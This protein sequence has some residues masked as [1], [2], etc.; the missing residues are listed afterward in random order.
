MA[1]GSAQVTYEV[2]PYVYAIPAYPVNIT[3]L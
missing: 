1:M 3:A 2:M